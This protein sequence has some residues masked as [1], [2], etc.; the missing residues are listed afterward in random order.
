MLI[1]GERINTSR[2]AV[3]KAVEERDGEFILNEASRQIEQGASMLDVNCGTSL[4]DEAED[5]LW[6]VNTIQGKKE[7]PISIDSPNPEVIKKALKIHSGKA[8]INSIT[9]EKARY[10]NILPISRDY[11]CAIIALTIDESGIPESAKERF[12]IA[13]VLIE[14]CKK[15]GI[16]K[17]RV[18]V[19]PC[20]RPIS[21]E[22]D[23][24]KVFLES[25]RLLK[26]AGFNTIAGLSNV[27]FGLPKRSL[28]NETFLSMAISYGL[29]A[30]IIDPL[31]A[32][33]MTALCI[34]RMLLGKDEYCMEY[35]SRY[36]EGK[37]A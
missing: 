33:L 15:Y 20:V 12:K 10:E 29:D 1:I 9:A 5:M 11:D 14:I 37:I 30:C 26:E 27:S 6:L 8:I 4:E 23:S 31:D 16:K 21:T 28:V 22:Q 25:I 18:Y 19:D 32:N 24:A 17:E 34:S 7:I 36:R 3:K 13:R 35:L 2:P